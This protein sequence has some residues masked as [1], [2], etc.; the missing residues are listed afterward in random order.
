MINQWIGLVFGSELA[1]LAS[2][3]LCT[4][5]RDILNGFACKY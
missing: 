3:F 1:N 5:R 4:F 2:T